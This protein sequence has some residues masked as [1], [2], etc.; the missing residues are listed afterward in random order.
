[1][2]KISGNSKIQWVIPAVLA[3]FIIIA[4]LTYKSTSRQ[5]GCFEELIEAGNITQ[6]VSILDKNNRAVNTKCKHGRLPLH[7]ASFFSKADIIKL[8]IAKGADINAPDNSNFTP[9][10]Y[11]RDSD[12]AELLI[13]NG[14]RVN[15]SDGTGYTPLHHAVRR[16]NLAVVKTLIENGADSSIENNAGATALS[17]A[18]FHGYT[19]IVDVIR[20]GRK[21]EPNDKEPKPGLS[22]EIS[23]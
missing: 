13:K 4:Y 20:T 15:V 3:G 2:E 6:I 7:F 9:L 19:D 11:A 16:Q 22:Q 17:I 14:A 5:N 8:L 10:F 18:E 23:P 12:T 1:M 21:E